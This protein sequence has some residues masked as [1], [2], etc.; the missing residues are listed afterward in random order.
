MSFFP[1]TLH[2]LIL[3]RSYVLCRSYYLPSDLSPINLI[4]DT[5]IYQ[6]AH[7]YR[8]AAYEIESMFNFGAWFVVVWWSNHALYGMFKDKVRTLVAA[9]ESADQG[10]A[11][12]RYDTDLLW[13]SMS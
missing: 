2:I 1:C 9:E 3:R 5:L 6:P 7:H 10:P 8:V 4:V 11:I 12:G 13:E